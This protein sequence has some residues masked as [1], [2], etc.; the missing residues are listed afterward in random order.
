MPRNTIYFQFL[1]GKGFLF[2]KKDKEMPIICVD[3]AAVSITVNGPQILA[4]T[5]DVIPSATQNT[6]TVGGKPVLLEEDIAEWLAGFA[7]D[8]DNPPFS[9]GKAEGDAISAPPPLTETSISTAG[10]ATMDTV[11]EATL[12]VSSPGD[13]PNGS[14]DPVP[15][16]MI[17]I[18][19]TDSAQTQLTGT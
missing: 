2:T 19:F 6:F 13:G 12:K 15:T 11:I 9:G 3:G 1:N 8:Y 16:I 7:T 17:T 4:T 5:E 18:E 14:K 10:M